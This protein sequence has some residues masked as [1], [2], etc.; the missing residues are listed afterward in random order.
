MAAAVGLHRPSTHPQQGGPDGGHGADQMLYPGVAVTDAARALYSSAA[1]IVK[2]R[3]SNPQE[4]NMEFYHIE[5]LD[6]DIQHPYQVATANSMRN[7]YSNVL[8]YDYNR[9]QLRT[10]KDYINASKVEFSQ[11]SLPYPCRYIA[12]QGPLP[13]T[14]QDFWQ[15]LFE[16][17]VPAIIMLTGLSE[18]GVVKC[19]QYF[20]ATLG[21]QQ[22]AASFKIQ[23]ST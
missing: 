22:S 2:Q 1:K 10:P 23:A 5:V 13:S 16:Q 11:P 21:Q 7:R 12:T 8:P 19:A 6:D 20:P 4:L 18:R 17:R 14:I 9:V 3:L 15:M